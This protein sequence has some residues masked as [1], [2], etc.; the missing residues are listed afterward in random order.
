MPRCTHRWL[1]LQE[2]I[3]RVH[4]VSHEANNIQRKTVLA[5]SHG[6]GEQPSLPSS[7]WPAP[8]VS[9]CAYDAVN[10]HLATV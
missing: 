2:A 10:A 9:C 7:G 3:G 5:S 1:A 6:V 8:S 4:C